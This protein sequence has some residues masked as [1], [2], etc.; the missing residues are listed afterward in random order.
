MTMEIVNGVPCF[1]CTEVE[2]AQKNARAGIPGLE[3]PN[4]PSPKSV[5]EIVRDQEQRS[6]PPLGVNQPLTS[7]PVGR[8]VNIYG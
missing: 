8:V 6:G 7:G 4:N 3:N 2:R 1:N 5:Q